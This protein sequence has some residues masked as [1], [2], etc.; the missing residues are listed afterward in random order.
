MKLIIVAVLLAAV[1][2]TYGVSVR[3]GANADANA[4]AGGGS[5][6]APAKPANVTPQ[7]LAEIE[8][9]LTEILGPKIAKAV[10]KL[11]AVLADGI[12][13]KLPIKSILKAVIKLLTILLKKGGLF[14]K[15]LGGGNANAASEGTQ[16]I[17]KPT[18]LTPA[19]QQQ[20]IKILSRTLG[21]YTSRY[22]VKIV[23][24]LV[25]GHIAGRI[26]L[27]KLLTAVTRL[28]RILTKPK[29]LVGKLVGPKGVGGVVAPLLG[30][31]KL[32]GGIL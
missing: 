15:L 20:L 5:A 32:L 2:G 25:N 9:I 28:L 10:T 17:G 14:E 1:V 31:G 13:K 27:H 29:G 16:P 18:N 6:A 23:A 8:A 22:I 4:G 30:K 21:P 11:I 7:Q 3:I 19:T 24:I 26:P 12:L